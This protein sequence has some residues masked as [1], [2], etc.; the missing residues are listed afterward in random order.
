MGSVTLLIVVDMVRPLA[1]PS[2][3]LSLVSYLICTFSLT[4]IMQLQHALTVAVAILA[5]DLLTPS[6]VRRRYI[7]RPLASPLF[8]RSVDDH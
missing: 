3:L 2:F 8:L 4:D 7:M 1:S 5:T 6:V